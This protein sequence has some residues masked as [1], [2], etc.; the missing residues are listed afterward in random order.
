MKKVL[1]LVV[2]L[3]LVVSL[4]ACDTD[5]QETISLDYVNWA[6]GI[7]M[8][9]LA[10]V[11]LEDEMGYNVESTEGD[12]GVVF[13]SI[14]QGD[15]DFFV[16]GWFPSTHGQYIDEYEDQYVDL[17]YN[18]EEAPI[19]LVVPDYVD[20][21]SID[22]LNEYADDFDN[23]IVGIDPGAGLMAAT[24]DAIDE[25]ELTLELQDLS[26]PVMVAELAEAIE[27]D[28]W[29]VVTGW[30]PHYK[31]ADYD[32][33]FLD[34]PE[35]VY[36][37]P[38]NIHTIASLDA[39]DEHPDVVEFFENFYF[40]SATLGDLM[41][42]FNDHGDEMSDVEVARDWKDNNTDVWEDWVVQ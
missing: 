22:Q 33:K 27:N 20:I 31:F 8:N 17:G 4:A 16:D 38:D 19:G 36:G 29:V 7:A 30:E 25:Y 3:T 39:Y 21:D 10:H 28:E 35:G 34:D 5:E 37:E 18:F 40:D 26:G 9:Y 2:G 14:A 32:L 6:E 13:T 15:A 42:H 41:G 12:P 11:I 1:A 23:E 24:N